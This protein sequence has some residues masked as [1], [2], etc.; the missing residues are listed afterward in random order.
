MTDKPDHTE[1][2]RL[3]YNYHQE[4]MTESF[5]RRVFNFVSFIQVVMGGT[6]MADY[7][8]GLIPGLVITLLSAYMFIYKPGEAASKARQQSKRYERLI[9]RL[10]SI[11]RQELTNSLSDV[12][13]FDSTIVGSLVKPAYIRAAISTG[14]PTETIESERKTLNWMERISAFI[15]GGIPH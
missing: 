2:F 9:N 7:T 4:H 13:E 11:S 8:K 6:I 15:A 5:N 1:I 10:P 14:T 3:H 12:A